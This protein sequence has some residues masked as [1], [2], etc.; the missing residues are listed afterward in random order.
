MTAADRGY[1]IDQRELALAM[2]AQTETITRG[3]PETVD[4]Y[5]EQ[6]EA[7]WTRW[8]RSDDLLG[9]NVKRR[10]GMDWR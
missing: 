1:I 3:E 7:D 6:G 4:V 8:P 2:N 5:A 9:E 10:L